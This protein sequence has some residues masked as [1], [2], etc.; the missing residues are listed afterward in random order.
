MFNLFRRKSKIVYGK[1]IPTSRDTYRWSIRRIDNEKTLTQ[2]VRRGFD[3]YGEAIE[4]LKAYRKAVKGWFT[5][6]E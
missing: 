6:K 2:Q 5:I 1:V 4:D 3:T